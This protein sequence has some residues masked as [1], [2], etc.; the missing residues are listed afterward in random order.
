M[1]GKGS[2][3][4][5]DKLCRFAICHASYGVFSC[6]VAKGVWFYGIIVCHSSYMSSKTQQ[7]QT[8]STTF[9]P[10]FVQLKVIATLL[11]V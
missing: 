6:K 9:L 2:V 7:K 1:L 11:L 5:N 8:L 10:S 3:I 4:T